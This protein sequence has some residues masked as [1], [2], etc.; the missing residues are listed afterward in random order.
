M[1]LDDRLLAL[2]SCDHRTDVDTGPPRWDL[3]GQDYGG[4]GF[5]LQPAKNGP[6]VEMGCPALQNIGPLRLEWS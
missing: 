4:V 6:I 3:G 1:S 2:F 5:L